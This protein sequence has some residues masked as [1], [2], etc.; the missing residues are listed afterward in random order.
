MP[1]TQ[2]AAAAYDSKIEGNV[3]ITRVDAAMN[4]MRKEL[5]LA[6]ADGAGLLRD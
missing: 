2:A 4:W 1:E 3:I 5:A 6:D